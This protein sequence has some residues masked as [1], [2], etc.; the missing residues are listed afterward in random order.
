MN[1]A[2]IRRLLDQGVDVRENTAVTGFLLD[3]GRVTGVRTAHGDLA[4]DRVV[5]ACGAWTNRLLAEAGTS[6]PLLRMVA[7]RVISPA[8]G[9]PSSMATV[10]VPDLFG[11]WLREHRGGLTWGNGDGYAPCTTQHGGE[12][13]Q[14]RR[15]ELVER[16]ERTFSPTLRKLVPN[17]DTSIGWWLQGMPAM[18][19]D[20]LFYAGPVPS[21]PGLFLVGGDNEAGVTHGPG[22]GRVMADLVRRRRLRL[23]RRVGVPHRPLRPGAVPDRGRR[24]GGDARAQMKAEALLGLR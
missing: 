6:V 19:P 9:V 3:D 18:T 2:L 22:L 1:R 15:E 5:L 8:S 13:G 11:L 14:P 7:T 10:M 17:H 21:V 24:C 12:P 20:R 16:L 4:A 23:G